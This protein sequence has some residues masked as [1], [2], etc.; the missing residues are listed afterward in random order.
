MYRDIFANGGAGYTKENVSSS[1]F[2]D[3]D[4]P[5]I[6]VIY[7]AL[8][9]GKSE[10]EIKEE[11]KLTLGYID[12]AKRHLIQHHPDLYEKIAGKAASPYR[13]LLDE[14][15]FFRD[16]VNMNSH[17]VSLWHDF[18]RVTH[19]NHEKLSQHSDADIWVWVNENKVDAIITQ[20]VRM[21]QKLHD[22][23]FI[24][25]YDAHQS[26]QRCFDEDGVFDTR[27][28]PVIVQ[29]APVT[30]N[31][32]ML[33]DR[34]KEHSASVVEFMDNP[35]SVILRLTPDGVN[36]VLSYK[37]I[38]MNAWKTVKEE[39]KKDYDDFRQKLKTYTNSSPLPS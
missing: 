35:D 39:G 14:N 21:V 19:T 29:I 23:S 20:D 2:S 25:L 15:M 37:A 1:P 30:H 13:F 36:P 11:Y 7:D 3:A 4:F 26:I 31:P 8:D 10:Q 12:K 5:H 33:L 27:H 17:V 34:L 22:L 18:G 16:A 9:M 32:Q 28:F 6:T 24:A 38:A